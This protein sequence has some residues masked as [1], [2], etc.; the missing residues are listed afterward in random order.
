M[1]QQLVPSQHSE[2]MTSTSHFEI[3]RERVE[4]WK[5]TYCKGASDAEL[6]QFIEVCKRT[7]LAPEARQIYAIK[8]WDAFAKR[9][10]L[11]AQTSI[12]GFRV[13]AERSKQYAGQVGPQWCGADGKWLDVWLENTPPRAA[14]TGIL[15]HDFKEVMWGVAR[16]ESYVVTGKD[17]RP[18]ANWLKM[19][20][21]MLA[22]CSESLALRRAF[23]NDLSGLYTVDEMDRANS[24]TPPEEKTAPKPAKK[25]I[26]KE[27]PKTEAKLVDKNDPRWVQ[28]LSV[29]FKERGWEAHLSRAIDLCDGKPWNLE[30]MLQAEEALKFEKAAY[31]DFQ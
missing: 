12:D 22:K 17:G 4:L 2:Q 20:D 5:A 14:R 11:Q 7:G 29:K 6:L 31:E 15:R 24:E 3:G 13:I 21:L 10:V 16:W 19:P 1:S 18:Q 25:D 27:L 9:E 8:R 30:T 23:P 26:P 28:V